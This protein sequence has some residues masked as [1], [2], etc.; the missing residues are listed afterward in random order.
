MEKREYLVGVTIIEAR[1]LRGLDSGGTS[2]PFVKILCAG[3]PPQVSMKKFQ[4]NA[5]VWNQSFTFPG[6]MMNQ[7]ELETFELILEVYD[8]NALMANELIGYYSI[9]LSTLYRNLNHEFYR[10]WLT[11]FNPDK[12]NEIQGYLQVSCFIVGPNE[13]PPAH[14]LNEDVIEDEED[15]NEGNMKGLTEE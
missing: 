10:V 13:R 14:S 12:P 3:L 4:T 8:Y 5:V 11:L 6:L 9:G 15:M 1:N 7:Y 2:D